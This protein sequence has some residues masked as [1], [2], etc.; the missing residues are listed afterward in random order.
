MTYYF[1]PSIELILDVI[2]VILSCSLRPH[3]SKFHFR[4]LRWEPHHH[5]PST[6]QPIGSSSIW[7][8]ERRAVKMGHKS[9]AISNASRHIKIQRNPWKIAAFLHNF[10][11][12]YQKKSHTNWKVGRNFANSKKSWQHNNQKNVG[13]FFS[14]VFLQ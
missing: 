9:W 10:T 7:R 13:K 4:F 3:L 1:W 11:H 2:R 12:N 8:S 14:H 5:C 6:W